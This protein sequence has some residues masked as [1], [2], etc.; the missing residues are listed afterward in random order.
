MASRVSTPLCYN[1]L[2]MIDH[3]KSSF[4]KVMGEANIVPVFGQTFFYIFP[5]LLLLLILFNVFDVYTLIAR[6]FKLQ[7][8]EFES[9]FSHDNI[10]EGKRLLQRARTDVESQILNSNSK[11]LREYRSYKWEVRA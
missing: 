3:Q 8:F 9:D 2:Q 11:D 5:I 10:E 7:K 6:M 1:F 4:S